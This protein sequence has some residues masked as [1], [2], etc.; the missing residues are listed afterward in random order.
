MAKTTEW[1][2]SGTLM[3]PIDMLRYDACYPVSQEDAANL[4]EALRPVRLRANPLG[5]ITVKLRSQIGGPTPE[6]W[7]SFSW[8]VARDSVRKC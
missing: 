5:R 2:V 1:T 4:E 7:A 6:R 8:Y 3:F